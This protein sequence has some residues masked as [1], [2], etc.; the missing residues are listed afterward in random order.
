MNRR[1]FIQRSSAAIAAGALTRTNLFAQ[2]EKAPGIR[3]QGKVMTV[4]GPVDPGKIGPML[5][6]EHVMSTFG[7]DPTERPDYATQELFDAVVPYMKSLKKMG[8]RALADCTTA[9]F[10]RDPQ[11]LKDVSEKTGIRILS[12]TGYYGA[13]ND[14]YVP[15]HAYSEN[16]EQLAARWI[17]EWENGIGSTGIRPG[18]IKTGVDK[19]PLSEIDGKLVRAAAKTHLKTGLV[20]AVHT[21]NSP[22]SARQQLDILREENVHPSAWIWVHANSVEI[23][24]ELVDTARRGAWIEFDGLA[25][26]TVDRHLELVNVMKRN[27][28]LGRV[29]LS[30]DG[31]LFRPEN[32]SSRKF[33]ALFTGLI[34]VLRKTGYSKTELNQMTVKN[35][36]EAFSVRI[37]SLA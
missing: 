23:T 19:G 30:H 27:G 25:P 9:Y 11:V 16:A 6:H 17:L 36:A 22:E 35:P 24:D 14:R 13:A 18:F 34:P 1:L 2:A 32:R 33:D 10:G 5:P 21:G 12:N 28:L 7:S 8:L 31:N 29:L 37:R 15:A 3:A 4:L 26:E 20:V